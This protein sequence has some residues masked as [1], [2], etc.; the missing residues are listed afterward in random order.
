MA[1]NNRVKKKVIL[2][3]GATGFIGSNIVNL[4]KNKNFIDVV[5][6][7]RRINFEFTELINHNFYKWDVLEEGGPEYSGQISAIIHCAT[8]NDVV[9]SNFNSGMKLTVD[10]T[11]NVL[12]YAVRNRIKEVFF[13]STIQVFGKELVG[14][15]ANNSP[16]KCETPYALNHFYGEELCKM[17]HTKYGLNIT[18]IRPT[19]VYGLPQ[20]PSVNRNTLVPTC[21]VEDAFRKGSI[22]LISSGMQNRNFIFNNDLARE[23]VKLLTFNDNYGYRSINLASNFYLNIR[24]VANLVAM[25]YFEKTGRVLPIYFNDIN[26]EKEN[27]FKIKDE[28][29]VERSTIED[30]KKS[31]DDVISTLIETNINI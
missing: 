9:S 8:A 2:V 12:E 7:A 10:G 30:S 16:I 21:F 27:V 23:V 5:P 1:A 13:L 25:K 15:I 4:I 31:F 19:N 18:V 11:H 3:T 17:F 22:R 14:E 6:C 20:L 26:L 24:S 29:L 28:G